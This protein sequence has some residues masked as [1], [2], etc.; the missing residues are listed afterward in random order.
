MIFTRPCQR[1]WTRSSYLCCIVGTLFLLQNHYVTVTHWLETES[2][3]GFGVIFSS[4][5]TSEAKSLSSSDSGVIW[6]ASTTELAEQKSQARPRVLL[7]KGPRGAL[8]PAA[9]SIAV[10]SVLKK[11]SHWSSP[12]LKIV[13]FIYNYYWLFWVVLP[14]YVPCKTVEDK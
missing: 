1:Q 10:V 8:G 6:Y 3:L 2:L 7:D 4:T 12:E 5:Q 14:K 9:S 13:Y 11:L